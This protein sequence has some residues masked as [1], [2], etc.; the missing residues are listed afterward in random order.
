MRDFA[1]LNK[2][3]MLPWD[4]WGAMPRAGEAIGSDRLE[5]FDRLAAITRVPD[6][7][8][9]DLR[10]LYEGDDRVRVPAR[11]FN[12]LRDREERVA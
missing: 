11:V 8:F 12:A 2:V 6:A 3:E 9:R 10:G 5:L 4:V 7:S 1:A